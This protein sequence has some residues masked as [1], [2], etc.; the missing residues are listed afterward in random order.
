MHIGKLRKALANLFGGQ[1]FVLDA[2]GLRQA[3]GAPGEVGWVVGVELGTGGQHQ[4]PRLFEQ[5]LPRQRL[6]LAPDAVG[7][8]HD[9]NVL[10]ALTHRK[11]GN[12][13]IAMAGAQV[14]RRMMTVD[15]D[16][17]HPRLR[18]LVHRCGAHGAQAQNHCITSFG[19]PCLPCKKSQ[20]E[21]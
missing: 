12:A 14:V 9:G 18:Q 10:R 17:I 11:P 5:R 1:D 13:R 4:Q 21:R 16:N 20:V 19:H 7:I 3:D 15:T 6:K 8:A 2:V